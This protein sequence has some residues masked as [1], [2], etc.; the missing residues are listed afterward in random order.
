MI[1]RQIYHT[2]KV[3]GDLLRDEVRKGY[4]RK[5][6]IQRYRCRACD[7]TRTQSRRRCDDP[8]YV[9]H[10]EI[11]KQHA[12]HIRDVKMELL[13]HLAERIH[14]LE[15][16]MPDEKKDQIWAMKYVGSCLC[17]SWRINKSILESITYDGL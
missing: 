7:E 16:I 4:M 5:D 11:I 9:K 2:C 8:S 6:G 10:V 12:P 13:N 3:H 1:M 15:S 14:A 17:N